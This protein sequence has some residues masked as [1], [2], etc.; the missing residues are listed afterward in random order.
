MKENENI[1][2][3]GEHYE[4]LER[5][6]RRLIKF[7]TNKCRD[8]RSNR[9]YEMEWSNIKNLEQMTWRGATGR[10]KRDRTPGHDSII[11]EML[12]NLESEATIEV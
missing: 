10:L 9:K 4:P 6:F 7:K 11:S 3:R 5:T 1:N 8:G 12:Q 2:K